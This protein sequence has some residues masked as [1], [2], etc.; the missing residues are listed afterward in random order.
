[1]NGVNEWLKIHTGEAWCVCG[2]SVSELPGVRGRGHW[3]SGDHLG[4]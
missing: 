1:M 4:W 3:K 2:V